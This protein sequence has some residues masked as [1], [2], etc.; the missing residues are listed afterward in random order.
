MGDGTPGQG[1]LVGVPHHLGAAFE[2][3]DER[4]APWMPRCLK[5]TR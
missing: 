5:S 2:M 4:T 1:A 3:P